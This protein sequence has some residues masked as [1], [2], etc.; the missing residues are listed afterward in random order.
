L[1]DLCLLPCAPL[2]RTALEVFRSHH[3]HQTLQR[4]LGAGLPQ[5]EDLALEVREANGLLTKHVQVA[6]APLRPNR[7]GRPTE[8]LV[9][10]HD[11]SQLHE[12]EAVRKDFVANVSHELRTPLSILYGYLETLLDGDVDPPTARGFLETMR[13]H[14]ERLRALL[15]GLLLLAQLESRRLPLNVE[16]VR[17]KDCFERVVD[18][19]EP[20]I[21]EA[22]A[23]VTVSAPASLT[24][25]ADALRL[26]QALCNLVDNALK[27]GTKPGLRL[28]LSAQDDG[29]EILLRVADNGP[30][31]PLSDQPHLF[32]RFYRVDKGRCREAGGAG[33]G[34]SIV[35]HAV[36]AHGGS[37]GVES[38]PGKGATFI[39]RFPRVAK[40]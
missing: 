8:L 29:E 33:L 5:F 28:T 17:V 26:E 12:L 4:A 1:Q 7:E 27:H 22:G 20:V 11:V 39:L 31:I 13:R 36:Q 37:V 6:A 18:R 34:L 21:A 38:S 3:L 40:R 16:T 10:F 9:V 35:K 24:L 30:G 32:E 15:E 19:F 2:G 14:A 25:A 23:S